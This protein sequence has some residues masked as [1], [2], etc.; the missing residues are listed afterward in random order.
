MGLKSLPHPVEVI[1][2]LLW[3]RC[4]QISIGSKIQPTLVVY[5][6]PPPH[7]STTQHKWS[8]YLKCA[9]VG[10]WLYVSKLSLFLVDAWKYIISCSNDWYKKFFENIL[11]EK[12]CFY[13]R[14]DY[15]SMN[16]NYFSKI[17]HFV[18]YWL[19]VC[20][21]HIDLSSIRVFRGISD[22]V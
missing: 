4:I 15:S 14:N 5:H 16:V 20:N 9:S 3:L 1:S 17:T 13:I 2:L 19:E 6:S 22:E 7:P 10:S 11:C 8:K 18:D 12:F 21:M